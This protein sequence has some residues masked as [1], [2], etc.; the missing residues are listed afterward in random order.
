MRM[1]HACAVEHYSAVKEAL[2]PLAAA[3]LG[4]GRSC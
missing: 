3:W 1:R 2:M 4:P